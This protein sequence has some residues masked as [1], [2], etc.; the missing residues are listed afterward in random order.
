[1]QTKVK[2]CGVRRLHDASLIAALGASHLG[3]VIAKDSPRQA[4]MAQASQIQKELE[5]QLAVVLV[6]RN[7]S[8]AEILQACES[9]GIQRVQAHNLN[10]ADAQ[11]LQAQG[12]FLT[13][14]YSLRAQ[15]AHLPELSPPPTSQQPALLDVGHGGSGTPFDWAILAPKAPDNTFI[16]GG[17]TPQN[18]KQLLPLKPYGIDLSSGVESAPGCKDADKLRT[19]FAN[20]E[21]SHA[22]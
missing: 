1:M 20:L 10:A 17:I 14:V 21:S 2:I 6:C 13:K 15:A 22:H 7:N 8:L 19:L 11:Q 5:E 12:I 4:S 18:V 16:A 3:C 9:T